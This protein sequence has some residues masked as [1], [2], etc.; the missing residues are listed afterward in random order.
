MLDTW[1]MLMHV[2]GFHPKSHCFASRRSLLYSRTLTPLS[3][4]KITLLCWKN[5]L[6]NF[7]LVAGRPVVRA[8]WPLVIAGRPSKVAYRPLLHSSSCYNREQIEH[9]QGVLKSLFA[10][11]TPPY[12][13]Q[14][15]GE[16]KLGP[17]TITSSNFIVWWLINQG[18]QVQ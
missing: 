13:E 3:T 8:C 17:Q 6:L 1:G 16:I 4:S 9:A 18:V 2:L 15:Q 11:F 14:I 5:T 10:Q 12:H 7:A